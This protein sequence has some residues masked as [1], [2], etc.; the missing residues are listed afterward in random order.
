MTP[1]KN[2]TAISWSMSLLWFFSCWLQY[3][4]YHSLNVK[5]DKFA[6]EMLSSDLEK[7][8]KRSHLSN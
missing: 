5:L 8:L 2:Q 3:Q 1:I 7:I 6:K 4:N